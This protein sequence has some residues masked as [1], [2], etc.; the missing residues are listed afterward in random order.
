MSVSLTSIWLPKLAKWENPMCESR[1]RSTTPPPS[2]PDCETKAIGPASGMPLIKVELSPVYMSI[3]PTQ[4]G[5]TMRIP[6]ELVNSLSLRSI[7]A[8][9]APNSLK[10]PVI[11]TA[12]LMPLSPTAVMVSIIMV[13]GKTTTANS[14]GS[15]TSVMDG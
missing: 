7:S 1:T 10:P 12:A 2:A 14:T 9:S 4:F 6:Y 8:P 3:V 13:T 15:G 11:M 5:P